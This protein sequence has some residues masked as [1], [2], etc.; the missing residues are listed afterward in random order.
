MIKKVLPIAIIGIG[1]LTLTGC[2]MNM[3]EPMIVR[4][5]GNNTIWVKDI[6]DSTETVKAYKV[7]EDYYLTA[8][9][10]QVFDSQY[11]LSDGVTEYSVSW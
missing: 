4:K 11:A 9:P 2:A 8:E 1:A 7:K 10:G 6:K 5:V 3:T